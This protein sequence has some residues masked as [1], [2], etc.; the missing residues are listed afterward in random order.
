MGED[1]CSRWVQLPRKAGT[2]NA[3]ATSAVKEKGQMIHH[4]HLAPLFAGWNVKGTLRSSSCGTQWL[5]RIQ[6][7]PGDLLDPA[8]LV[9]VGTPEHGGSSCNDSGLARV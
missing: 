5:R 8:Y 7:Y 2:W 4:P 9:Q 3:R 1:A 6:L